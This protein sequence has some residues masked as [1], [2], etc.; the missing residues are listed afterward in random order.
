[1]TMGN[2]VPTAGIELTSL[3]F[4]ASVLTFTSHMLPDVTT[5]PTPAC[6]C[7]LLPEMSV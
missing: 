5:I 3:A 6:L 1:M 4:Q 2:I 7:S